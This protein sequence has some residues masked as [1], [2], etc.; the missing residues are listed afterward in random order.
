[1]PSVS[2]VYPITKD[3]PAVK[4]GVKYLSS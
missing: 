2:L 1:M 4:T 3:F